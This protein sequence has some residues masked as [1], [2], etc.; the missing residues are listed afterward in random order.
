MIAYSFLIFALHYTC[1]I[2]KLILDLDEIEFEYAHVLE[3]LEKTLKLQKKKK[4][5]MQFLAYKTYYSENT[6]VQYMNQNA[7]LIRILRKYLEEMKHIT[8]TKLE[9]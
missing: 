5:V 7:S 4:S 6:N 2:F 1:N 3:M 8:Q 9:I